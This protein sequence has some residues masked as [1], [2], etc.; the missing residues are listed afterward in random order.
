MKDK[1]ILALLENIEWEGCDDSDAD[2]PEEVI[3]PV[4]PSCFGVKPHEGLYFDNTGLGHKKYCK[5]VEAMAELKKRI[6]K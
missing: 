1:E 3:R 2:C 6:E 5:L 4:C